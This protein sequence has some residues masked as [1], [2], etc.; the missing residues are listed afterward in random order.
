MKTTQNLNFVGPR[1]QT[2]M[3]EIRPLVEYVQNEPNI[4]F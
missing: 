1:Q 2:T 4:F 3:V